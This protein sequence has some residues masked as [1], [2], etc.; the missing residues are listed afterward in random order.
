MAGG[1]RDMERVGYM[2][3]LLRTN[4]PVVLS[5]VQALLRDADIQHLLLDQNMSIMEGSIGILPRRILVADES[6]DQARRLMRE[7]DVGS[8]LASH[9]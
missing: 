4:D 3:E 8:H 6:F 2:R 7:A 5:F 1:W 9:D